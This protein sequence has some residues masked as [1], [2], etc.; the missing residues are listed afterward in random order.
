MAKRLRD[1]KKAWELRRALGEMGQLIPEGI[2]LL[3]AA[4]RPILERWFETEVLKTTLATDAVI[5]AFASISQPGTAYV[6]L[7]HVF[8]EVNGQK[9]RW[10]HVKG[11]MGE[12]TQAMA[13]SAEA[14]GA[15][16]HL[17]TAVKEL[18][19]ENG[20]AAAVITE[21]GD[22]FRSKVVAANVNPKL[23]F[24]QLV[25]QDALSDDFVRQMDSYRCASGT[26]RM[27]VALKELPQGIYFLRFT[28]QGKTITK[29]IIKQ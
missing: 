14:H 23:L 5:G 16:I 26:F 7:H 15:E 28:S 27:N 1:L 6:L 22:S 18:L 9:G 12:I 21:N 29:K 24:Q 20:K 4:A 25:R 11:G 10:G 19:I 8:G 13:R 3:T 17:N 2:E